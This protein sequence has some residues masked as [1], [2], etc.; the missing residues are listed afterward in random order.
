MFYPGGCENK[1]F[2]KAQIHCRKT[3][4]KPDCLLDKCNIIWSYS[5]SIVHIF[6]ILATAVFIWMDFACSVWQYKF[7]FTFLFFFAHVNKNIL[8]WRFIRLHSSFARTF[9]IPLGLKTHNTKNRIKIVKI[10]KENGK[11][12]LGNVI[13]SMQ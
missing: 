3:E 5:T 10:K 8:A 11:N 12:F 2:L 7:P 1:Q 13:L 6:A 4:Q 9:V